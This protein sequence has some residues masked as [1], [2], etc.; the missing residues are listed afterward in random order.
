MILLKR[1]IRVKFILLLLSPTLISWN[2][3]EESFADE[4]HSTAIKNES[5]LKV[6]SNCFGT[7]TKAKKESVEYYWDDPD[8]YNEELETADSTE[9]E[10]GLIDVVS[11]N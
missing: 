11:Q 7:G 2:Y 5:E 10:V 9:A 3:N 1:K 8:A 4:K 6:Y